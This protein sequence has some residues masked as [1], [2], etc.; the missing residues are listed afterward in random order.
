[1][2]QL[3]QTAAKIE[4]SPCPPEQASRSGGPTGWVEP[5]KVRRGNKDFWYHRY[6]WQAGRSKIY[7]RH[8]KQG[9]L[10]LIERA[11]ELGLSPEAIQRL[12]K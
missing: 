5:Y 8:I 4:F 10:S 11:I 1:M 2:I 12:L 7:H 9:K 3:A 6:C